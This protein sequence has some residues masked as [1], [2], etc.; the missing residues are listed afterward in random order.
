LD[1]IPHIKLIRGVVLV[2]NDNTE[3]IIIEFLKEFNA[4][5]YVRDVI[6]LPEDED[7]LKLGQT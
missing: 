5:Y 6:L 7:S 1:D 4:E 3:K 2:S